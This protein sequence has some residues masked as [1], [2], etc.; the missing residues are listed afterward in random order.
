MLRRPAAVWP[1]LFGA[2]GISLA[3]LP[4][5]NLFGTHWNWLK[6]TGGGDLLPLGVDFTMIV[7]AVMFLWLARRVVRYRP[8]ARVIRRARAAAIPMSEMEAVA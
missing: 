1:I 3:A 7:F 2:T 6:S 5:Y 4:I 8:P